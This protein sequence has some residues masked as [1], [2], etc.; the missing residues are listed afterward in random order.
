[1]THEPSNIHS[2]VKDKF[3]FRDYYLSI[4]QIEEVTVDGERRLSVQKKAVEMKVILFHALQ[5]FKLLSQL[6]CKT[7]PSPYIYFLH[8]KVFCELKG[9]SEHFYWQ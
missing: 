3:E 2:A 7:K 6:L 8:S 4:L 5:T 1:M 9:P